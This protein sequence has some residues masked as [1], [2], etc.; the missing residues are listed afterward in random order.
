MADPIIAAHEAAS[1]LFILSGPA[2]ISI[3]DQLIRARLLIDRLN[4]VGRLPKVRPDQAL[5]ETHFGLVVI[6]G[7]GSGVS[8]ALR[9]AELGVRTLLVEREK[10]L[11]DVQRK[12]RTRKV[13]AT[14]Y[15]WPLDDYD[16]GVFPGPREEDLPLTVISNG[17]AS[18]AHRL[19]ASHGLDRR[20]Y[21]GGTNSRCRLTSDTVSRSRGSCQQPAGLSSEVVFRGGHHVGADLVVWAAGFGG[22]NITCGAYAGIP[23]WGEDTYEQLGSR[24]EAEPEPEPEAEPLNI[25][26]AGAGDGALQDLLRI[27]TGKGSAREIMTATP[28]L[29]NAAWTSRTARSGSG[30]QGRL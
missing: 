22:E 29:V 16:A 2:P 20:I 15:N 18:A 28:S 14:Q 8:A 6:G 11:F 24:P 17:A 27:I 12:G 10:A 19:L 13:C 7:G 4:Q 30:A 23:F 9:A 3:R 21:L 1:R 26:I 25:L 5:Q